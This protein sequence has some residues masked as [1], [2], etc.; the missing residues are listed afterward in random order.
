MKLKPISFDGTNINDGTNYTAYFPLNTVLSQAE[1]RAI[2]SQRISN[3]PAF[4]RKA[5]ASRDLPLVIIPRGTINTQVDTLKSVF[6]T[7]EDDLKTFV[8]QDENTNEYFTLRATTIMQTYDAGE[9]TAILAV[10]DPIWKSQTETTDTWLIT[11][12]GS[13][14]EVSSTGTVFA[15]P[16]ITITPTSAKSTDN[17][18]VYKRFVRVENQRSNRAFQN[19]PIEITDGGID[20]TN[21]SKFVSSDGYDFRVVINGSERSRWLNDM[22]STSTRM[23]TLI[24][25]PPKKTVTLAGAISSSDT[26]DNI[27]VAKNT[28]NRETMNEMRDL[29]PAGMFLIGDEIFTYKQI[30][31][32][33][34][35]LSFVNCKRAQ[36]D[37][38]AASHAAGATIT[39]LPQDVY[40][41]Y[42]DAS[43]TNPAYTSTDE[44]IFTSSDSNNTS[45]VYEN[46]GQ[47][48]TSR[49]A[50]WQYI[51]ASR[52]GNQSDEYTGA[53]G[54]VASPY[55]F[56]G[57]SIQ[58]YQ[59][60]GTWKSDSADMNW[61][62]FCPAGIVGISS[63]GE[64]FASST[65]LWV[66]KATMEYS[67]DGA[68]WSTLWSLSAPAT[69][70]TWTLWD[71]TSASTDLGGSYDYV[72]LHLKGTCPANSAGNNS[73]GMAAATVTLDSSGVPDITVGAEV[74]TY[75]LKAK[76][77][78]ETN[79]DTIELDY[80]MPLNET[81]EIDCENHLVT[82][83]WSDESAIDALVFPGKFEWFRLE[84]GVNSITYTDSGTA[85]VTVNFDFY[86]RRS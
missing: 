2:L 66:S 13:T 60:G 23:W 27:A 45:W 19:Y 86:N 33:S 25:L 39:L 58:S 78:N 52:N 43:V 67:D 3:T 32:N 36:K 1:G 80:V 73:L 50:S 44:P 37:T 82:A 34:V 56:A 7:F 81:L 30:V 22:D 46:F 6:D 71:K 24:D 41:V 26:V 38:T 35:L 5:K 63:T 48:N 49:A 47:R 54:G 85:G 21:R 62:L 74:S 57:L 16:V 68:A 20:T 29:R 15:R 70:D 18:Y 17:G 55:T 84:P 14:H 64:Y 51:R 65:S 4:A 69:A 10:P 42:G 8:A 12:S 9:F 31:N 75:H 40:L 72:R 59:S 28:Q 53:N 61:R 77:V 76:I 79:G 83:L 11:A